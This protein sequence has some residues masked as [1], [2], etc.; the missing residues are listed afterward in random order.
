MTNY[1]TVAGLKSEA[2]FGKDL[3]TS[4]LL[5]E[6]MKNSVHFIGKDIAKFHCI[7][8]PAFLNAAF[9]ETVMPQK[10]VV[11]GHW[12]KD[13]KKM[14]KSIGNVIEPNNLINKYGSDSVRL[15]FLANGPYVDDREF[16]EMA[17]A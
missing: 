4:T 14:S 7:Y 15:Y 10:V 6:R 8:W 2:D 1:L 11:H 13:H 9:R 17:L 12:R 3:V 16:D 5:K